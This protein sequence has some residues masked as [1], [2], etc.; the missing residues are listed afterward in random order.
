MTKT[1]LIRLGAT[2]AF[3]ITLGLIIELMGLRE[4]FTLE[5]LRTTIEAN[6]FVGIVI[7]IGLFALGNLIQIP[8]WIFMAGAILA[9]GKVG[10]GLLTYA[11]AVFS[12]LVTY[13]IIGY[14][15]KNALRSINNK[16]AKKLLGHL[17]THPL[18]SIVLL[19]AFLGSSP[20]L[21]YTLAL[22]G[23][24]F[25]HHIKGTLIG[26]AIPV[27]LHTLLFDFFAKHLFD[28]AI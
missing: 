11:A 8:G 6:L 17:D 2:V 23:V 20:I 18:R 9:L 13:V 27:F 4:N 21:N 5:Y 26:L 25:N 1:N 14:I 19:R 16:Y 28:I 22:S 10:G 7:F 12:C 24:T 3:A 15:G